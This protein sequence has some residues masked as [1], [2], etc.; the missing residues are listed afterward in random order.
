M[1]SEGSFNIHQ[2]ET[3]HIS[4]SA[5]YENDNKGLELNKHAR[6]K[7]VANNIKGESLLVGVGKFGLD[8]FETYYQIDPN[9]SV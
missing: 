5:G 7:N 1:G 9:L 8:R 4:W 6:A 3:S 2:H